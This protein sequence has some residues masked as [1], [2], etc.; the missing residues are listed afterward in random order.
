MTHLCSKV[1]WPIV[2]IGTVLICSKSA[3]FV[4]GLFFVPFSFG[5]ILFHPW[6][7]R[8]ARS[9]R[10]DLILTVASLLYGVWFGYIYCDAFYWNF[11]PQSAIALVFVGFYAFPVLLLFWL[12]AFLARDRKRSFP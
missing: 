7:S 10:S 2:A 3:Y 6:L 12:A 11:D 8:L 4:S 5:P 9:F 1:T